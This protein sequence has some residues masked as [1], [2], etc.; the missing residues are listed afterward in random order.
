MLC[1]WI[2]LVVFEVVQGEA[3]TRPAFSQLGRLQTFI[4]DIVLGIPLVMVNDYCIH[5]LHRCNK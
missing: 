1:Y 5:F 4:A 2:H 3:A